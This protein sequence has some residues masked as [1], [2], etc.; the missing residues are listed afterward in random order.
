MMVFS[1]F[2]WPIMSLIDDTSPSTSHKIML[3][4][5]VIIPFDYDT[6][7]LFKLCL[8]PAKCVLL[9]FSFSNSLFTSWFNWIFSSW[10]PTPSF[11]LYFLL[12]VTLINVERCNANSTKSDTLLLPIYDFTALIFL[13][14]FCHFFFLLSLNVIFRMILRPIISFLIS[15]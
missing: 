8:C 6:I 2:S 3:F 9:I 14:N 7:S 13:L 11:F 4:S 15:V 12:S 1:S 10:K 5:K